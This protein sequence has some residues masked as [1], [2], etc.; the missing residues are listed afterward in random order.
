MRP[1]ETK[2]SHVFPRQMRKYREARG[3]TQRELAH[4]TGMS[5][6][7]IS[8]LERG[9]IANPGIDLVAR[10]T[11]TLYCSVED[12]IYSA[13]TPL[14]NSDAIKHLASLLSNYP[15][16]QQVALCNAFRQFLLQV[17]VQGVKPTKSIKSPKEHTFYKTITNP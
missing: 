11:E 10:L 8:K 13:P 16:Q 15:P 1:K 2:F 3:L 4:L 12:L 9:E 14:T 5:I 7:Y 17:P 6:N